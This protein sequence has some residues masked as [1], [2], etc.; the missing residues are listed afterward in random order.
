MYK[1]E[2]SVSSLP[3]A[4]D[5]FFVRRLSDYACIPM[6]EENTDYL[7]YLKWLADGNEPLGVDDP[8]PPRE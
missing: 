2:K 1:L 6:T 5:Y 7:E 8:L 4:P 3:G